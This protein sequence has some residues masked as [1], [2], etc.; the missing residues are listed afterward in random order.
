M[1]QADVIFR[2]VEADLLRDQLTSTLAWRAGHDSG[3]DESD[4]RDAESW[5]KMADWLRRSANSPSYDELCR[6]RGEDPTDPCPVH[7]GRCSRCVRADAVRRNGGD[8]GGAA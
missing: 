2:R 3:V 1:R 5:A 4:D 8:W 7:C 6:R